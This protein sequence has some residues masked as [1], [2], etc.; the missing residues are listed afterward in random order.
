MEVQK[1]ALAS[2]EFYLQVTYCDTVFN[3]RFVHFEVDVDAVE[4]FEPLLN[5]YIEALQMQESEDAIMHY[6]L[7][8]MPTKNTLSKLDPH[9]DLLFAN[10]QYG[11]IGDDQSRK[12]AKGRAKSKGKNKK[13]DKPSIRGLFGDILEDAAQA[14][15]DEE[16]E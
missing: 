6:H 11:I 3:H 7:Q 16:N 9:Q 5:E 14:L 4:A 10:N 8:E 12:K 1:A 15:T 13:K 2:A